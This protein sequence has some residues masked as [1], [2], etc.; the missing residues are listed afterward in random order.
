MFGPKVRLD[1]ELLERARK[2]ARVAGFA[3]VDDFV[4]AT[5]EKELARLDDADSDDEVRK[6]LRGLGYIA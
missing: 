4:A 3:T 6:R 5:L 2:Y 1:R